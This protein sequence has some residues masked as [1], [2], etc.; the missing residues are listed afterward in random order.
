MIMTS[1]MDQ[2]FEDRPLGA[3]HLHGLRSNTLLD[4]PFDVVIIGSGAAGAVAADTFVRA[5]L[6]T[7]MLEEGVRLKTSAK[8]A[9]VD[10]QTEHALAGNCAQ[11]WSSQGWPWSTRNL[12]GGTVFYGGASFRYTEFDFDPSERIRVEGLP[13][14]W[15]I[16]SSDLAPF[17]TEIESI[18]SIDRTGFECKRT[19]APITL[20]LP[21]EH[22]WEGAL[23]LGLSPRSTPVAIDRSRC[24]HCSLCITA[25]CTRGAKRDVVNSL[26]GPLADMPNLLLLTGVK[27]MALTQERCNRASSVR[28]M[29][30]TTGQVRS[31]RG[32]RFVL[33]CNAIQ[34][35]AL[36]LRSV[37]SLAPRGLGNEHDMVGRGLCMK[38]SEYSQGV[39]NV[40]RQEV[41]DHPIGYRGPFSTIC[42]FDHYLDDRCPTGVGGLIYEAKHDDYSLIPDDGLV[43]RVETILADHPSLG[44][45]VRLSSS[46]DSWGLPRLMI[47]YTTSSKDLARLAYMVERSAD[48]LKASGVR[49]IQYEASNFAMGSTHLH[50]TCRAGN[51]PRTSVVDREGKLHSVDNVYVVDGSYMPYPGGVNPTLTIQAN[52]LRIA[53]QI[54]RDAAGHLSVLGG[55]AVL[56]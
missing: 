26:L 48:W 33:A 53:R 45:R 50:G 32:H 27:A 36:L 28:C 37:S 44:N 34:T 56:P 35:A 22:L 49:N 12:G 6:R 5:G 3:S 23:Q 24:D 15:P 1:P 2:Y 52:A 8:N 16:G 25:Q 10:A 19:Q 18:L 46:T 47:D 17:Y 29:D 39:V 51:D 55:A 40:D 41:D 54:V 31:I 13:V 11:G 42:T 30:T 21:A 38:L 4:D 14:K 7:L 20:S 43:L 9:D